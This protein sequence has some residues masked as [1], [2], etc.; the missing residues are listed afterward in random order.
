M[1]WNKINVLKGKITD[2]KIYLFN[3]I[4][5][6]SLVSCK[7]DNLRLEYSNELTQEKK[8][9]LILL[10]G[11]SNMVGLGNIESLK[12]NKLPMEI[13]YFNFGTDTKLNIMNNTFGPEVGIAR[14]LHEKYPN[15]NYIIIKYAVGGSSITDWSSNINDVIKEVGRNKRFP[16]LYSKLLSRIDSIT[17]N[18]DTKLI[19]FLWMQGEEDSKY[20]GLGENYYT[21]YLNLINSLRKDLKQKDLPIIYGEINLPI[22]KYPAVDYVKKAQNLV[23]NNIDNTYLIKTNGIE[24][25]KDEVHFSSKG[26]L[27]LGEKFGNKIVQIIE[28]Q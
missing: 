23:N 6:L 24:K 2:K 16:E 7:N 21:N 27:I 5:V 22:K 3:I 11:Q 26:Y 19:A 25:A 15:Q 28:N 14:V 18:Y 20:L 4:L 12:S 10:A 17:N 8:Y 9:K 13:V 1:I